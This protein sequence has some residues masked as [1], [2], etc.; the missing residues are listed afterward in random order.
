MAKAFAGLSFASGFAGGFAQQAVPYIQQ[1]AERQRLA[2]KKEERRRAITEGYT[3]LGV[4]AGDAEGLASLVLSGVQ[5]PG[6]VI[7]QVMFEAS[8]DK[9]G[10][11]LRSNNPEA[12][13]IFQQMDPE[14]QRMYMGRS[15][16]R[17]LEGLRKGVATQELTF[18]REKTKTGDLRELPKGEF[19]RAM[20][21][22]EESGIINAQAMGSKPWLEFIISGG[23]AKESLS[24]AKIGGVPVEYVNEARALLG[25]FDGKRL[26]DATN[27]K[28]PVAYEAKQRI[29]SALQIGS[30]KELR[31]VLGL[32]D[33]MRY[34]DQAQKDL[35]LR[36][37]AL[38]P[39]AIRAWS[40]VGSE[41]IKWKTEVDYAKTQPALAQYF[42]ENSIT[43][44][45]EFE[46]RPDKI[47]DRA[48]ELKGEAD[49][50]EA[51]L[52]M[53]KGTVAEPLFQWASFVQGAEATGRPIDWNQQRIALKNMLQT[54]D[55][56]VVDIILS[57]YQEH[58]RPTKSGLEQSKALETLDSLFQNLPA[59]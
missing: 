49:K 3:K 29:I 16:T 24:G 15:T 21:L 43:E 37:E 4:G 58:F 25:Q 57:W 12:F 30:E 33:P 17:Q 50:L 14:T 11:E 42:A 36:G 48:I 52:N 23:Q 44:A 53:P 10:E 5:V 56:E 46:I 7:E 41:F 6:A 51:K 9:F 31:L 26:L 20:Q 45:N 13:K 34:R 39:P 35:Q 22:L 27:V 18:L 47:T 2:Q 19:D 59:E 38:I 40:T 8:A 54:Q 55:E 32:P 1:R 28:D